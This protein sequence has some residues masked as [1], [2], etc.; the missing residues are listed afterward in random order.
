MKKSILKRLKLSLLVGFAASVVIG[1]VNNTSNENVEILDGKTGNASVTMFIPD[2]S[3]F[4]VSNS[5]ARVVA[6]QTASVKFG[7]DRGE[8]FVYLDSVNL[9]EAEKTPI[10]EEA[11]AIGIAGYSYTLEFSE[12][13]CG[14]YESDTLEIQ[15]LDA[16]GNA[17]CKGT[18]SN[19]V[20]VIADSSAVANFY[21]IPV[22]ADAKV[23]SLYNGEMK[24]LKF[25]LDADVDGIVTISVEDGSSYPDA[26]V[27]YADGSF[28]NYFAL[29]EE[30]NYFTIDATQDTTMYYVGIWANGED[31]SSYSV[32]VSKKTENQNSNE[33]GDNQ[34]ED[35]NQESKKETSSVLVAID[36][37]GKPN[38]VS[39]ANESTE[40]SES[41]DS[42]ESNKVNGLDGTSETIELS[43]IVAGTYELNVANGYENQNANEKFQ[44]VNN[45]AVSAKIDD[46]YVIL[47]LASKAQQG[48]IK[49]TLDKTMQVEVTE[50]LSGRQ[51]NLYG[52]MIVSED[53]VATYEEETVSL[54]SFDAS[55]KPINRIENKKIT[56]T[57]GTYE[58]G[59][60]SSSKDSKVSSISFTETEE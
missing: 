56:L 57:A 13:P 59:A 44:V 17:I 27:F 14:T 31:I 20:D 33:D 12:I 21:T 1:C 58:L 30:N 16:D 54:D 4:S 29:S 28:K 45:I 41:N 8:G 32:T 6:P 51:T 52:V 49:F 48:I 18:N 42:N 46:D 35:D 50:V 47:R 3:T 5:S 26:V 22:N 39:D 19:S 2:Y 11:S 40:N 15:L 24:F 25:S 7:Y 38:D 36:G 55:K 43:A 53:G 34:N 60:Y 10:S 37:N 23:G 9:S